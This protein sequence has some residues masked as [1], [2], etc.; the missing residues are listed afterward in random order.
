MG[1]IYDI[2]AK[3]LAQAALRA[4]LDDDS[5]ASRSLDDVIGRLV[6]RAGT[7]L[8]QRRVGRQVDD[9]ADQIA[10]RLE[11]LFEREFRS[12]TSAEQEIVAGAAAHGVQEITTGARRLRA[13]D[14][15][16]ARTVNATLLDLATTRRALREVSRDAEEYGRRLLIESAE[17]IAASARTRTETTYYVVE[18]IRRGVLVLQTHIE[19][20]L[21]SLPHLSLES[22]TITDRTRFDTTYQRSVVATFDRLEL[23]GSSVS[24]S[25]YP[26]S[27]SYIDLFTDGTSASPRSGSNSSTT[28]EDVLRLADTV[29]LTGEAGSGKTTAIQWLG[30][31][32]AQQSFRGA[33]S[34]LNS[35]IPFVIRLRS[36][37]GG[38]NSSQS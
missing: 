34:Y 26:L 27:L 11:P 1:V 8:N 13:D 32:S 35:Y 30:V 5:N 24:T 15:S 10:G 19:S 28:I 22:L 21:A 16:N 36:Y 14:L 25:Q 23:F 6:E 12:V 31:R 37:G 7:S 33:D 18:D 3:P 4:W 17:I 2:L 29:L 9:V 20:V 38:R